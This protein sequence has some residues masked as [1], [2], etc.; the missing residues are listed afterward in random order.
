VKIL[1]IGVHG[2]VGWELNRTLQPL[3]EVV[4]LDYPA[5]DLTQ[6]EQIRHQVREVR[7]DLIVNAAAYTAVDKAEAEPDLAMAING[8]APAILAGEAKKLGAAIVHYSTDY[9]FDGT[10]DAA[11]REE[12]APNPMN[13]YGKTKLAGDRAVL[14]S[15]CPHLILRVSWVYGSRGKNF[16]LTILKLAREKEEIRVVDDQIGS[17]LW[18][19]MIAE[20][21]AQI[22]VQGIGDLAGFLSEKGGLYHLSAQGRTSW[23]GFARAILAKSP[24][25]NEH[26]VQRLV[27]IT[28]SEYPTPAKR[29]AF[30][31]L[32]S[33]ALLKNF[34]LRL[35]DWEFSLNQ[36]LDQDR[37]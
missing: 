29:P 2:Q 4:A 33:D 14:A 22:L 21:T 25:R 3:G 37:A 26:K 16:M 24:H 19:R 23:F 27:P 12:D 34:G 15:G 10:R 5:I 17:P 36:V 31:L 20:I 1:L 13:V 18:S 8:A 28:S 9:V 35:P 32:S 11:Y 30:S 6:P 7:P